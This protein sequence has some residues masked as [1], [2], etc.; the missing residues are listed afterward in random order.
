MVN[1]DTI[2]RFNFVYL[3]SIARATLMFMAGNFFFYVAVIIK[4]TKE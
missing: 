1:L 3:L 4:N 2:Y